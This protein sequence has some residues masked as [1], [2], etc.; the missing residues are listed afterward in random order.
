MKKILSRK[1][2]VIIIVC[3]KFVFGTVSFAGIKYEYDTAGNRILRYNEIVMKSDNFAENAEEQT[4]NI[5]E[6]ELPEMKISIFPNPTKGL[7]QVK[8]SNAV[9]LQNAEI[10]LYD[11]QGKLIKQHGKLSELTIL[12]ISAQPEGAYIMQIVS[13]KHIVSA[14]KIIKN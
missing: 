11:P 5:F 1:N 7:L 14:W 10:L 4:V 12:D 3:I 9:A 13:G 2:T 6:N 8:I